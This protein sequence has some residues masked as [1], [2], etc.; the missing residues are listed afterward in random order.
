[1][2][3]ISL[4]DRANHVL[5]LQDPDEKIY[6]VRSLYNTFL[7]DQISFQKSHSFCMNEVGFPQN[8]NWVNPKALKARRVGS[9]QGRASMIHAVCHIE[10]NAI[11]LAL[12][13]LCRFEDMPEQYYVDWLGIAAEEAYHFHLLNQHLAGMG[14]AYGDFSVHDGL[15]QMA[16][17]TSYD[18]LARMACVPR[19]LEARGLDVAPFMAEKLE[20]SGDKI[21]ASI[22]K[23]IFHDEK[24][25]VQIGNHWYHFLCRERQL[26]ALQ[27][28]KILVQKHAADYLRGPYNIAARMQA[29]F[30][31]DELDYIEN[32]RFESL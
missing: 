9:P 15:W 5:A 22:L 31:S 10:F 7:F 30:L 4:F 25:H 14:Y 13:A 3:L 2:S 11:N 32:Y 16:I 24:N 18:V 27:T 8:L 17:D 29:G 19:L 23:I 12:D 21:G 1:M 20:K 6:C 28:F 26:D